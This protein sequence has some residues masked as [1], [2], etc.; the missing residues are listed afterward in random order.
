MEKVTAALRAN[1]LVL[2]AGLIG[3]VAGVLI[4]S[5]LLSLLL[6]S[7]PPKKTTDLKAI[8]APHLDSA[9][10]K[11]E[12]VI[13][14]HLM[15]IRRFFNESKTNTPA[16]AAIALGWGSKWRLMKDNIPF[17]QGGQHEVYIR[18]Q[19]EQ[20]VFDRKS[21]ESVVRLAVTEYLANINSIENQMLV[22]LRADL[23]EISGEFPIAKLEESQLQA[24]F[25]E[26]IQKSIAAASGQLKADVST[27][28]VSIIVGEV[29]TQVAVRLGASAAILGAGATSVWVTVGIGLVVGVIV[30]QV[31]AWVWDWWADPKG[32]LA[33]KINVKL[34]E[35][36]ILICDGDSVGSGGKRVEGLRQRFQSLA[37]ERAGL[38]E[39]AILELLSTK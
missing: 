8:V 38:R 23:A 30:D 34:D 1:R 37:L 29:L 36:C 11:S 28:L 33:L 19:F 13:E 10:T 16:F 24:K 20:T 2:I 12:D 18:N 3:V 17:N 31:V 5:P 35:M 27:Q 6:R 15:P 14:N 21:L 39:K 9:K 22:A 25:D 26:A 7:K 32:D 4:F